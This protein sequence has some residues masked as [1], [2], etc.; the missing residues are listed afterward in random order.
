MDNGTWELIK[1]LANKL[2]MVSIELFKTKFK[3]N[4]T[5]K[6]FNA[7]MMAIGYSQKDGI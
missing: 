5:N 1:L 2:P 4:S 3:V 7:R 6:K